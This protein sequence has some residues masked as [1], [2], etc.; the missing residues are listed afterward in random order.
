MR[1]H[2]HIHVSQLLQQGHLESRRGAQPRLGL[3]LPFGLGPPDVVHRGAPQHH[4]LPLRQPRARRRPGAAKRRQGGP[5]DGDVR[6]RVQIQDNIVL[7]LLLRKDRRNVLQSILDLPR[8]ED[9][10]QAT[11]IG[12]S[13]AG[14][15]GRAV[16]WRLHRS[17]GHGCGARRGVPAGPG[18]EAGAGRE[19]RQGRE[20]VGRGG[21]PAARGGAGRCQWLQSSCAFQGTPVPRQQVQCLRH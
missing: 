16:K 3:G 12:C 9:A 20:E 15:A 2:D 6:L 13:T 11:H 19:V 17:R 7:D 18:P 14:H 5:G 1:H 21:L 10:L 8:Q 4:E